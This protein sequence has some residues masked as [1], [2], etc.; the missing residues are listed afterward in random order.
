[1]KHLGMV[2]PKVLLPVCNQPIIQYHLD[3][4]RHA[5]VTRVVIVADNRTIKGRF[6]WHLNVAAD[7][8][9]SLI[10]L[11]LIE[12]A[13]QKLTLNRDVDIERGGFVHCQT[14][15]TVDSD[16]NRICDLDF[17]AK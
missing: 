4:L 7:H 1:M 17:I 15:S 10:E 12:I 6:L 8:L 16:L 5:G 13:L 14:G 9:G 2:L 3:A 11:E